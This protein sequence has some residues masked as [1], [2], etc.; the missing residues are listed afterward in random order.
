M[1]GTD[2]GAECGLALGHRLLATARLAPDRLQL[3]RLD[4]LFAKLAA[5][6]LFQSGQKLRRPLPV[7]LRRQAAERKERQLPFCVV[8]LDAQDDA[9]Q[10]L[11]RARN[12]RQALDPRA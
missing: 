5:A 11:D 3:R 4:G 1:R 7:A 6:Q 10:S 8:Q 9:E 2:A 12:T